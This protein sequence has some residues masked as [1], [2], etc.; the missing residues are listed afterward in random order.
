M[1]ELAIEV[2]KFVTVFIVYLLGDLVLV[3][4]TLGRH[5]PRWLGPIAE[6]FE[7]D[8]F[9]SAPFLTGLFTWITVGLVLWLI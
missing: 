8:L 3:G 2:V 6:P 5:E 4:V 7:A 1:A 9:T